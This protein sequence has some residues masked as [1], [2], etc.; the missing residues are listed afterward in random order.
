MILK[1]LKGLSLLKL[2]QPR[3][4]MHIKFMFIKL[5]ML[6]KFIKFCSLL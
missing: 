3:K 5:I 4:I 6:I 1:E 2:K